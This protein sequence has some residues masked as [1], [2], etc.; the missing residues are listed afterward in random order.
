MRPAGIPS[1]LSRTAT[2]ETQNPLQDA[3]NSL[4]FVDNVNN[5]SWKMIDG[6][7]CSLRGG[8]HVYILFL[9]SIDYSQPPMESMTP[10]WLDIAELLAPDITGF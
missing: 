8:S 4:I 9:L 7:L 5:L 2:T 3:I 6:H 10:G 1:L